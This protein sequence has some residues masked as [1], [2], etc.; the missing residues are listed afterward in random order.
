MDCVYYF[1]SLISFTNI[2]CLSY[3]ELNKS[4]TNLP[5]KI[6]CKTYNKFFFISM[7]SHLSNTVNKLNLLLMTKKVTVA[8]H[9]FHTHAKEKN[10]ILL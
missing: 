6:Y 8:V 4:T 7:V 10:L 2:K 9:Y 5:S 1:N 3:K